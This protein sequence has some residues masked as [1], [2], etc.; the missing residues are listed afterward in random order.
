MVFISSFGAVYIWKFLT[1]PSDIYNL[2]GQTA[3]T[4]ESF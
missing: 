2:D 4:V 3:L 1:H